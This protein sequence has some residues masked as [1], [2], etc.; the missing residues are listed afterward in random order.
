MDST[1]WKDSSRMT[2]LYKDFTEDCPVVLCRRDMEELVSFF[3]NSAEEKIEI[4]ILHKS[5]KR[6][7][8]VTTLEKRE[9][10]GPLPGTDMLDLRVVVKKGGDDIC[11]ATFEFYQNFINYRLYAH[12]GAWFLKTDF[13]IRSFFKR[14]K[15]WYAGIKRIFP[16]TGSLFIL[17]S[18]QR[19]SSSFSEGIMPS[20]A[21]W[22]GL[23][24]VMTA[25]FL[26]EYMGKI[27]PHIWISLEGK[28]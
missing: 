5:T 13:K 4:E 14:K 24:L 16:Y 21:L 19:A 25:I 2:I 1:E 17:L 3:R 9:N 28:E 27:F 8:K 18:G 11:G 23:T 12:D 15:P 7:I 22:G 20:T 26:L 6:D 10:H